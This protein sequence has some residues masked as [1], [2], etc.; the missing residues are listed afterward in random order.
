VEFA[1]DFD[2]CVITGGVET[3]TEHA[4]LVALGVV[5]GQGWLFGRPAPADLLVDEGTVP[6]PPAERSPLPA[7]APRV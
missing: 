1:H 3:A 6:A 7:A 5:G 2:V 4:V